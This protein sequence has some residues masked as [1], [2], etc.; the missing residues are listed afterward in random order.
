[1][2]KLKYLEGQFNQIELTT[3]DE[4]PQ[5]II[6]GFKNDS[7]SFANEVYLARYQ[8]TQVSSSSIPFVGHHGN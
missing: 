5:A 2:W 7:S 3:E 4:G 6:V 1:M 8:G